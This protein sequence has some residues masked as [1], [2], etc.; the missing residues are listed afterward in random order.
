MAIRFDLLEYGQQFDDDDF[1]LESV[2]FIPFECPD[3]YDNDGHAV[4][5]HDVAI[6]EPN[7]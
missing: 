5:F 1:E 2:N 4:F 6:E 7:G 3:I